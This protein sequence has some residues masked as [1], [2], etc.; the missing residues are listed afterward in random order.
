MRKL[1][2]LDPLQN[3]FMWLQRPFAGDDRQIVIHT[4]AILAEV[5]AQGSSFL[6]SGNALP[7]SP[8]RYT[9]TPYTA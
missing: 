9:T 7:S 5:A 6:L 3:I 8:S 4:L 1:I 2:D